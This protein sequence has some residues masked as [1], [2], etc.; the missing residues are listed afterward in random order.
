PAPGLIADIHRITE[1]NPFFIGEFVRMLEAEGALGSPDLA[2]LPVKLPAE[3]RATIRRRLA[4][5]PPDER[6][7]LDTA[8]VVG[9]DFDVVLLQVA[10]DLPRE[11]ALEQLGPAVAARVVEEH[12]GVIGRFRFAHALIRETLYEDLSPSVRGQLH[13]RIGRA[14]EMVSARSLERPF[15]ELAHHFFRAAPLGDALTALDYAE[16]AGHQALEQRGYEE[17]VGHFEHAIQLLALLPP[18]EPRRLAL[19]LALGRASLRASDTRKARTVFEQ[20]AR[21]A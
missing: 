4:P 17:A 18:D 14:L 3:L 11:R 2:S 12:P 5:L 16:R 19:Q 20:A 13:Q 8:A 9:R 7:L 6:Q 15:A 10:C 21:C 1:G